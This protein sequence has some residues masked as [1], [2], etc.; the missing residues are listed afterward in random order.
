M[1]H[2]LEGSFIEKINNTYDLITT[3]QDGISL[4]Y[5]F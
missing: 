5:C 2:Y 4:F 1:T 3:K